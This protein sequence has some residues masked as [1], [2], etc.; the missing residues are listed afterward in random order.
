MADLN[1]LIRKRAA[2]R[3]AQSTQPTQQAPNNLNE[4]IRQKAAEKQ[5][6][7]E[8]QQVQDNE[9]DSQVLAKPADDMGFWENAGVGFISGLKNV[10]QGALDLVQ[11][12]P[13]PM[14]GLSTLDQRLVK[15]EDILERKRIEEQGGALD[16]AGGMTGQITGEIAGLAPLGTVA[17]GV[18][19]LSK[20][21]MLPTAQKVLSGLSS[22]VGGAMSGGATAGA[23][24]ANPDE[25]L[26]G[27]GI[28]AAGGAVLNKT[29]AGLSR[30]MK[31][32][33]VKMSPQAQQIS[34][35]IEKMTGKKPFI[36]L[37]KAAD[38]TNEPLTA[39][40]KFLFGDVPNLLPTARA[41]SMG[42]S[43][44]LMEDYYESN[45]REGWI[46][47][48]KAQGERGAGVLRD[49]G[50]MQMALEAAK[51]AGKR[52][53][54]SPKQQI[55]DTAARSST[56]G[57]YTPEQLIRAIKQ[58]RPDQDLSSAPFRASAVAMDDIAGKGV[59]T[60]TVAARKNFHDLTKM[61]GGLVDKLPMLGSFLASK[62]VQNFLMGN[63]G[64]QTRLKKAMETGSGKEVRAIMSDIRRAMSGQPAQS[65][66]T[67]QDIQQYAE[68]ASTALRGEF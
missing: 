40:A 49:T 68:Q 65:D 30:V 59:G 16:T 33:L 46:G 31:D 3:K 23:I 12:M 15:D 25:R 57:S 4:V 61:A 39:Q 41:K 45:I 24:L 35:Y 56:T 63:T 18:Q 62:R 66:V 52:G 29:M 11:S 36:P 60:S 28:G 22:G 43:D 32:G 8:Q 17:K 10:G 48:G 67:G 21:S 19:A 9:F 51:N 47:F 42:Q 13:S 14:M 55:L 2:E 64:W 44:D 54:F 26:E 1:E 50:D 53:Q 37:G 6:V 27:A 20:V 7:V 34:Q 58:E 5:Q 38:E